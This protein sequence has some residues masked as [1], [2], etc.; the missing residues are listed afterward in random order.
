MLQEKDSRGRIFSSLCVSSVSRTSRATLKRYAC[1]RV[2]I[3]SFH[4]Q[5]NLES[6]IQDDDTD[7]DL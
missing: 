6:G 4:F 1:A 2:R 7:R 3:I 5:M